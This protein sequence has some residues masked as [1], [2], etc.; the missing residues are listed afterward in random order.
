M[1]SGQII[2]ELERYRFNLTEIMGRYVHGHNSLSIRRE[3][4]PRFRSFVI[5]IIDLLNDSFGKNQYSPLI[6]Q[7]FNEGRFRGRC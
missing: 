4:D 2:E 3:D 7:I 1:T 6:N 5:E